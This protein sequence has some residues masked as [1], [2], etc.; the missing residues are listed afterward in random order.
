[1]AWKEGEGRH[2]W[3]VGAA[4]ERAAVGQ[5]NRRRYTTWEAR[6]GRSL[7]IAKIV[8]AE[9]LPWLSYLCPLWKDALGVGI[10]G[11]KCGVGTMACMHVG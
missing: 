8:E 2:L 4:V 5:R 9:G 3:G 6:K 1:M 11:Q 10:H 7:I